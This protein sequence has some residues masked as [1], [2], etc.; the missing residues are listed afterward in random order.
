[1][2]IA[3]LH[4]DPLQAGRLAETLRF[5][6]HEVVVFEG[7]HA[8]A[9]S[10]LREPFDL[11]AAP[12]GALARHQP[13]VALAA[14][15]AKGVQLLAI[16]DLDDADAL[17]AL[18]I[19]DFVMASCSSEELALRVAV[20]ERRT[21]GSSDLEVAA[22]PYE[23]RAG[24]REALLHGRPVQLTAREFEL[25]IFLFRRLGRRVPRNEIAREVWGHIPHA[26]SRTLDA[27]VS[28]LRRKLV[29]EPANGYRLS[30]HYG[31]GYCLTPVTAR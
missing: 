31:H 20:L 29:L 14:M 10:L 8:F 2:R 11:L 22:P 24:T 1:M 5:A 21:R 3:F 26:A 15:R 28:S 9:A 16:A 18:P 19:D 13:A 7:L 4:A 6:G 17:G 25:A 12:A 30:A 27:H 23:F